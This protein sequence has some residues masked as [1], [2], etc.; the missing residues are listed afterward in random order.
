MRTLS[1]CIA[2]ITS[3]LLPT[4]SFAM[5]PSALLVC[6]GVDDTA[7]F[8]AWLTGARDRADPELKIAPGRCKVTAAPPV[9]TWPVSIQGAGIDLSIIERDYNANLGEAIFHLR[10]GTR[11]SRLSGLSVISAA[12]RTGGHA[13]LIAST[14]TYTNGNIVVENAKFSCDGL[15]CWNTTVRLDGT[16]RLIEPRGVRGVTFSNVHIFGASFVSLE[17]ATAVG[18]SYHG[19]GIYPASGNSRY[20]GGLQIRGIDGYPSQYIIMS[21][22]N[23]GVLNL[24]NVLGAKIDASDM[25]IGNG[26]VV[27]TAGSAINVSLRGMVW[28]GI[29]IPN[30]GVMSNWQASSLTKPDGTVLR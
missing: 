16:T 22:S 18:F 1:L 14:S 20:S 24:S 27:E 17:L 19:G 25:G 10:E 5:D 23:V 11:G 9:I 30:G 7:A 15:N 6:G 3:I 29:G 21:V 2:F 26:Y 4:P 8:S 13:L 12:S 28:P